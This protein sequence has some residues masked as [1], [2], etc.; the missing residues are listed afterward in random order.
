VDQSKK[1][2]IIIKFSKDAG[3]RHKLKQ[4]GMEKKGNLEDAINFSSLGV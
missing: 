3:K 2:E 1:K 4:E